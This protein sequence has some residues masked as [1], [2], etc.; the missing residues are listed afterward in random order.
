MKRRLAAF[1]LIELLVVIAIIAL[2]VAI[3]LPSLAEARLQANTAVCMSNMSQLGKAFAGYNLDYDQRF[4]APAPGPADYPFH[5]SDWIKI[6]SSGWYNLR[7]NKGYPEQGVL[8]PYVRDKRVYICPS[9]DGD[10]GYETGREDISGEEQ[11]FTY[12]MNASLDPDSD[13]D[14]PWWP[15]STDVI[16]P[17][18]KILLF[19]EATPNDGYCAWW[20]AGGNL[21]DF[22]ASRHGSR[23]RFEGLGYPTKMIRGANMLF[24]DGHVQTMHHNEVWNNPLWCDPFSDQ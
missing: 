12:S 3:L 8:F 18:G 10:E 6:E 14:S 24:F 17:S 2:L 20:Y 23:R 15:A 13:S 5:G 22:M 16:R 4:P 19:E 9:D 11:G 1:T 21:D 7:A